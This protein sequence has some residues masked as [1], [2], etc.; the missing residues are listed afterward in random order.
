MEKF[1]FP[2]IVVA[3]IASV[4]IALKGSGG[5][6]SAPAATPVAA[7][8]GAATPPQDAIAGP[9]SATPATPWYLTYNYGPL[10]PELPVNSLQTT[11]T[12]CGSCN[13]AWI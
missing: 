6:A 13:Q 4:Y 11:Q 2:L 1:F 9:G 5:F 8:N 10:P 3:A 7:N 12:G